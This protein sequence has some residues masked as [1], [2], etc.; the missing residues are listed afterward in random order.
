MLELMPPQQLNLVE[1]AVTEFISRVIYLPITL[2]IAQY[3]KS[4]VLMALF[5]S[6]A[7]I[8]DFAKRLWM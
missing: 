4:A 8:R 6:S 5:Q 7:E 1:M 2:K 3:I